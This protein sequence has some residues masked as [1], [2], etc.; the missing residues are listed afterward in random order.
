MRGVVSRILAT[1]YHI[2]PLLEAQKNTGKNNSVLK[3]ET[4]LSRPSVILVMRGKTNNLDLIEPVAKAL[5]VAME[6][7]FV[8]AA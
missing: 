5:G 3:R 6:K 8:R 4:G 2:R 7:L 1:R